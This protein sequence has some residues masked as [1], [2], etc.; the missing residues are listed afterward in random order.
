[1]QKS[2]RREMMLIEVIV[3]IAIITLITGMVGLQVM[4]HLVGA[5]RKTALTD[6]QT[7]LQ[8][9]DL[10]RVQHGRYPPESSGLNVLVESKIVRKVPKDPWGNSYLYTIEAGEPLLRTLGADGVAGGDGEDTDL[11]SRDDLGKA[12]P[13]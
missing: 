11:T 8:G 7:L 5:R 10:Y 3:V 9:L 13:Q 2:S 6:M 12:A 1:M 4:N